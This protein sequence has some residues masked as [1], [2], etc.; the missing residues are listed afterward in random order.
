MILEKALGAIGNYTLIFQFIEGGNLNEILSTFGQTN[1]KAAHQ[2]LESIGRGG[3]NRQHITEAIGHLRAAHVAFKDIHSPSSKAAEYF[4]W[5]AM[6]RACGWD[7][8]VCALLC[9]CYVY[10]GDQG[11]ARYY[12]NEAVTA[13]ER[14]LRLS[15]LDDSAAEPLGSFQ[16]AMS[17]L[18]SGLN[19]SQF[20]YRWLG[21]GHAPPITIEALRKA[22][23]AL[24][25]S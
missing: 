20:N 17:S 9:I 14:D 19:P 8:L 2:A 6:D 25:G 21:E 18:L 11:N 22:R 5:D 1:L 12:I 3:D 13:A 4:K 16:A 23:S 7:K 15:R 24:P 10:L